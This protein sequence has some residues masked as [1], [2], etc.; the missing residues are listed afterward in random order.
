MS[1]SNNPSEYR[2]SGY[3][4]SDDL[5]A[6]NERYS[7]EMYNNR[8]SDRGYETGIH[9]ENITQG[10]ALREQVSAL[11]SAPTM[12]W[13][14]QLEPDDTKY[15]GRVV[16]SLWAEGKAVQGDVAQLLLEKGGVHPIPEVKER[17]G[18]ATLKVSLFVDGMRLKQCKRRISW[19][20]KKSP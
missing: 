2:F 3:G 20:L 4:V 8:H 7:S 12:L 6:P 10:K 15:A 13:V 14:Y 11:L 5:D 17:F 19:V 1:N 16:A 9:D 18:Y